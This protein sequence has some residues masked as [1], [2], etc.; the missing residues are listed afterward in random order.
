MITSTLANLLN[1]NLRDSPRARTLLTELAGR[2]V[3]LKIEGTGLRF[4]LSSDGTQ[5]S[6]T[7]DNAIVCDAEISGTPVNL[8]SLAGGE[9]EAAIRRKGVGI[10][11]DAEAAHRF[12]ELGLLL[13]PDLEEMLSRVVGDGP[14]HRLGRTAAGAMNW[15]RNTARTSARNLG[16]YFAHES[17]DLVPRAEGESFYAEVDRARE[18]IDR[19]EARV[20]QLESRGRAQ[21]R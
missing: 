18:A 5:L 3:A 16:E 14:A 17:G 11:G 15:A 21:P 19:L 4:V 12:R 1:R 9:P 13:R 8:L 7:R 6:L 20:R 10:T 2:S